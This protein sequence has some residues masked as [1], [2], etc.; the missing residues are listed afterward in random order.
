MATAITFRLLAP[1]D[2]DVLIYMAEHISVKNAE[3]A[4]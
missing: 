2:K 1:L 3:A 4:K